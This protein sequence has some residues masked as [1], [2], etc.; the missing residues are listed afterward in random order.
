MSVIYGILK[1]QQTSEYI[2]K[3]QIDRYREQTSS[4]LWE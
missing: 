4:Y 3:K 1:I 2:K